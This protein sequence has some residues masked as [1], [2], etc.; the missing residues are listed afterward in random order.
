MFGHF[1]FVPFGGCCYKKINYLLFN[2][3]K[4]EQLCQ[5]TDV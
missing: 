3:G 5:Y 2:K 4:S 1:K